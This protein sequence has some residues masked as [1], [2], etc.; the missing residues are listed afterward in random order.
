MIKFLFLSFRFL[1]ISAFIAPSGM[2]YVFDLDSTHMIFHYHGADTT[3]QIGWRLKCLGDINDDGFSDIAFTSSSPAGTYVFFGGD[4]V[5]SLPDYFFDAGGRIGDFLDYTGDG[6]PD[7]TISSAN[8]IYLFQGIGDSIYSEPADSMICPTG[9]IQY[10]LQSTGYIDD[11]SVGDLMVHAK[12]PYEGDQTYLYL[13]PFVAEKHTDWEYIITDYS[14]TIGS[15]GSIDFNADGAQDIYLPMWAGV[16]S[17]TT[18]YVSVFFG[19]SYGSGPDRILG[20]PAELDSADAVRFALAAFNIGDINGD[21]WEDLGVLARSTSLIYLCGT[22][23]DTVY[24]FKLDGH[25]EFMAKAGDING[26]GFNDMVIG[27]ADC[28]SGRVILYLG[29]PRFDSYRDDQ[30]NRSDLPPLFLEDVGRRVSSAGD[31]NGDGFDDILF[32]CENFAHGS[33]GDVFVFSG[34]DDIMTD[35]GNDPDRQLPH[36][37]V[38]KQNRPNPFNEST[39]IE[40]ELPRKDIISLEIRNSLGQRIVILIREKNLMSGRHVVSWDGKFENG[41]P[42]PSGVYFYKLAGRA[43]CLSR[44]MILLK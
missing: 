38:L 15:A 39:V 19:P 5:D 37:F 16:G 42:A 8:I 14:H 28:Y 11:D 40:F 22:G 23:A 35:V 6:I 34:G 1:A 33:P 18:S 3:S 4:P 10:W 17:D 43:F 27:G 29:G 36:N 24:D 9:L 32:S 41:E 30:I 20:V 25:C 44:K 12:D 21:G 26:D 13:N 31:F 7:L 2:S